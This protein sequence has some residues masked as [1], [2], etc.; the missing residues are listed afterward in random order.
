MHAVI[1]HDDRGN[2]PGPS[3]NNETK[4]YDGPEMVYKSLEW[5]HFF[6]PRRAYQHLTV[7]DGD[8]VLFEGE[9]TVARPQRNKYPISFK[10]DQIDEETWV[11]WL[12]R[13]V[14]AKI[15]TDRPVLAEDEEYMKQR[16]QK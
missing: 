12:K 5:A 4:K 2:R 14:R 10:P 1:L 13:E 9:L 7:Y 15:V 6:Q 3:F 8:K 16:Q 11:D